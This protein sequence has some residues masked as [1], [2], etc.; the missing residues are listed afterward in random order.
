[1]ALLACEVCKHDRYLGM[2]SKESRRALAA[3]SSSS[4]LICLHSDTGILSRLCTAFAKS[5]F[6]SRASR[7]HNAVHSSRSDHENVR[8][9][10]IASG[11]NKLGRTVRCI[12]NTLKFHVIVNAYQLLHAGGAGQ[13]QRS[14]SESRCRRK[15][16]FRPAAGSYQCLC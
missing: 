16:K 5:A 2:Q 12:L 4:Q 9:K 6:Q 10:C 14:C 13:Q 8:Y 3:Q 15:R 7:V 11:N 1:M